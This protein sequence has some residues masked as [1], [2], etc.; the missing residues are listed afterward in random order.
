MNALST[1]AAHEHAERFKPNVKWNLQTL[2]TNFQ[3]AMLS[4][5]STATCTF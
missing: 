5:S 4:A 1:A 2:Q 3:T